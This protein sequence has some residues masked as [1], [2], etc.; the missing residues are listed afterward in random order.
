MRAS[1]QTQISLF[2]YPEM[3]ELMP[4]N[5]VGHGPDRPSVDIAGGCPGPGHGFFGEPVEH[6]D[7][8]IPDCLIFFKNAI[9]ASLVCTGIPRV[10]ILFESRHLGS[11]IS[12]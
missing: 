11:V 12:C 7:R 2:D 5:V 6:G 8:R 9:E 1:D 10:I 3:P 4:G